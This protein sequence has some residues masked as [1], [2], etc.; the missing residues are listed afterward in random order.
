MT[1]VFKQLDLISNCL[2]LKLQ[3]EAAIFLGVQMGGNNRSQIYSWRKHGVE[4]EAISYVRSNIL[5]QA[6][7][8]LQ[9]WQKLH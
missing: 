8:I 6:A 7:E 2:S 3:Q 9:E 1:T 5:F 4:A